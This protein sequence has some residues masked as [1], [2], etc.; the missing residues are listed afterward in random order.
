LFDA[1]SK[2]DSFEVVSRVGEGLV[3]FG[4]GGALEHAK[5]RTEIAMNK[6]GTGGAASSFHLSEELILQ[7][8][9]T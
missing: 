3:T 2:S 7:V 1:P 8:E 9:R 5:S 4:G 6:K